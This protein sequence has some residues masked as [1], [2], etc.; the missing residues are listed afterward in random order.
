MDILK[1]NIF[2][3]KYIKKIIK[4]KLKIFIKINNLYNFKIKIY[5]LKI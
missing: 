1:F 4:L 2:M 3:R 5:I